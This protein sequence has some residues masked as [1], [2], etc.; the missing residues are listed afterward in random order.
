MELGVLIY[1][2][3]VYLFSAWCIVLGLVLVIDKFTKYTVV[4][5]AFYAV[6]TIPLWVYVFLFALFNCI[7]TG[8]KD[9]AAML[10]DDLKHEFQ[11]F[12]KTMQRNN[13]SKIF[14]IITKDK[15][16]ANRIKQQKEDVNR[17]LGRLEK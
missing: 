13:D 10:C 7:I 9:M 12:R 2:T 3:C 4:G 6:M 14:A 15:Y 11:G 8:V 1:V 16:I 5:T 17:V